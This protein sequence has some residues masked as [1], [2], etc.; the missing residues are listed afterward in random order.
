M[1][2]IPHKSTVRLG[3]RRLTPAGRFWSVYAVGILLLIY[4]AT[5]LISRTFA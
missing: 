1:T 3:R 2:T 5:D 4:M